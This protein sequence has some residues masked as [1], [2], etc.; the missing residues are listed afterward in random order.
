ME[1]DPTQSGVTFAA[2]GEREWPEWMTQGVL[3]AAAGLDAKS[4]QARGEQW[5][6]AVSEIL[7]RRTDA[8]NY[9]Q[10]EQ[11]EW[12]WAECELTYGQAD[13]FFGQ[14]GWRTK[15]DLNAAGVPPGE[16]DED[17]QERSDA[18]V[19]MAARYA[20]AGYAKASE[21]VI[22]ADEK[23]FR[24]KPTPIPQDAGGTAIE[25]D[26]A[27]AAML[28]AERYVYDWLTEGRFVGTLRKVI[29]DCARLGCGVIKGPLPK[30]SRRRRGKRGEDQAWSIERVVDLRPESQWVDPWNL[31][32]DPACG[33]DVQNGDYIFER[34]FMSRRQVSMLLDDPRYDAEAVAAIIAESPKG[35]STG[36]TTASDPRTQT[37]QQTQYEVWWYYG[38]MPAESLGLRFPKEYDALDQ[39]YPRT[40]A[41]PDGWAG[42]DVPV[43]VTM[44]H[45][46]VLSATLGTFDSGDFPFDVVYWTR[47]PGYWAGIGIIEQVQFPQ[48]LINAATRGWIENAAVSAGPQ[49]VLDD[50]AIFPADGVY[51]VEAN[52]IW[53]KTAD[54]GIDD[55]AKAFTTYDIPSTANEMRAMIEYAKQ[56]FE[57]STNM[58]LITQGQ[59]GKTQPK[60]FGGMSLLNTNANQL[61]RQVVE[62]FE[63]Q[64]LTPHLGRYYEWLIADPRVPDAA[65]GDF[66]VQAQGA[67]A[68]VDRDMQDQ[69]L[70]EML[71]AASAPLI[72]GLDGKKIMRKLLKSRRINPDDVMHT[73]DELKE[74]A[75]NQPPP[76]QVQIQQMKQQGDE[77]KLLGKLREVQGQQEIEHE[78]V[79]VQAAQ[80]VQSANAA[81]DGND[82]KRQAMELEFYANLLRYATDQKITLAQANVHLTETVME[83]KT[84]KEIAAMPLPG[85]PGQVTKPRTEPKGKASKGRAYGK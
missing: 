56:L 15:A 50:K 82:V 71:D 8:I 18:F 6:Q 59:S 43:M 25:Q 10:Q 73:D 46:Q 2:G 48:K 75:E 14:Q 53:L 28:L 60:T 51:R 64:L 34:G 49:I 55:V 24:F 81:A 47:R 11:I 44:I 7:S 20:D 17:I 21:Y 38:M 62:N 1:Q 4:M 39:R 32:P 83:L 65:K 36:A 3:P 67:V 40:S 19:R 41:N 12:T 26:A 45:D 61:L 37:Q 66:K 54:T 84:Q 58:P 29:F 57:E 5:G 70:L 33:E 72:Y 80:M 16:E 79:A 35:R 85:P 22:P 27:D 31:F 13:Q 76:P 9:R 69:L 52:K 68:L 30:R 74:M 77:K 23:L 42:R 78:R 63:E